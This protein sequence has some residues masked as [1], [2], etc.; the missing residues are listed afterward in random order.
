VSTLGT[1]ITGGSKTVINPVRPS[2]SVVAV[3]PTPDT[4]VENDETL[5]LTVVARIHYTTDINAPVIGI[6][7][8]D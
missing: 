3:D 1:R 5:S 4:C 6:I 2:T 8:I 7:P